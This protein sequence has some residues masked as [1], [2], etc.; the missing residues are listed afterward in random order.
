MEGRWPRTREGRIREE[1]LLLWERWGE[2]RRER[3]KERGRERRR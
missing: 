3:R 2:Q 1:G